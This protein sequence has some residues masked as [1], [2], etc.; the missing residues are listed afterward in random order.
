MEALKGRLIIRGGS[1]K[2]LIISS[3]E[4]PRYH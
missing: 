3:K 4:G 1:L 2:V